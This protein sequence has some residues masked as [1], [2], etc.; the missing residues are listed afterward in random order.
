MTLH[1]A[2][3]NQPANTPDPDDSGY[4]PITAEEMR[5]ITAKLDAEIARS[6]I[7]GTATIASALGELLQHHA[8]LLQHHAERIAILG[9]I[10]RRGCPPPA[11][12]VARLTRG[13]EV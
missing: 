4:E 12:E 6:F 7:A 1:D 11:G 3:G 5:K 8:E 10:V 9:E 2:T 13:G